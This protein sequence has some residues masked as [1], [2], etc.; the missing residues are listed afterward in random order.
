MK[1][2]LKFSIVLLFLGLIVFAF[3]KPNQN[4]PNISPIKPSE[5]LKKSSGFGMRAHPITKAM[6][7]HNGVDFVA[8]VGTSVMATADGKIVKIEHKDSGYGNNIII[9]HSNGFKTRYAQ[10]QDIKVEIGQKVNQR[11]LIG[12]VGSSGTSTGPH[13]HYEIE[14][15]G[16]KVDPEYYINN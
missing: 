5:L 2:F 12:T 11:D 14:F 8:H 7:M 3:K 13:L 4:I 16:N 9:K 10:L 1:H 6:K 15:N